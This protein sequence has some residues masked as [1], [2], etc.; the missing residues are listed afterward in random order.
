MSSPL[1]SAAD[2]RSLH[3]LPRGEC[4]RIERVD[5]PDD[6]QRL[7]AMGVCAGR[8]VEVLQHGDPLIIRVFG[9]RI[10][11]SARLAAHV[12]VRPCP[13]VPRCFAR[14]PLAAGE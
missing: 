4:G 10:G 7:M 8:Q 1:E 14:A 11:L 12:R 5:N 2:L 3:D 13:P 6:V 9:S